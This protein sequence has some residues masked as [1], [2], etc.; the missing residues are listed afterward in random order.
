MLQA[1]AADE[2][3][4]VVIRPA[5][6][7]G[8]GS[9]PWTIL[10]LELIRSNRF[11]LP[12]G[13]RGIF[14]PLYVDNLLDAVVA[15]ATAADA[16]GQVITIADGIGVS[17]RDFFGHYYRM[18]GKGQPRSLPTLAAVGLAAVPEVAGRIGGAPTEYNRTSMRYLA[19]SGTYSIEKARR[20]LGYEPAVGLDEGMRRTE[21]WLGEQGL[22]S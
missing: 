3:E 4:C 15:A 14:S 5:D 22:L 1:H 12:A 9:R 8:P 6:V 21:T 20:L 2:I 10:P 13:G 16:G 11:V 17:C 7:Y 19:R 18:L